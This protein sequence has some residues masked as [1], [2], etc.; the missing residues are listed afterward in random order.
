MHAAN[1]H[2][3]HP[4][5]QASWLA[6]QRA[7]KKKRWRD[8]EREYTNGASLDPDDIRFWMK[9]STLRFKLGERVEALEAAREAWKRAPEN[10]LTCELLSVT[11]TNQHRHS[12]AADVM[13][14]M[15]PGP[16]RTTEHLLNLAQALARAHRWSEV[17]SPCLEILGKDVFN[18]SAHLQ[19]GLAFHKMGRPR[20]AA[21]C[22]ETAAAADKTGRV[23]ALALSQLV[24]QLRYAAEWADL[25]RH[26]AALLT[27]LRDSDDTTLAQLVAFP[28]LSIDCPPDLQRRIARLSTN[29]MA[30]DIEPLP[31]R[32]PRAPG[33]LRIGYL[34][35]DFHSHATAL[36]IVEMLEHHDPS[37]VEVFLYCHSEQ[38]GSAMQQRL[39]ATAKCFRDVRH[40]G[41]AELA[42]LIRDDGIDIVIDLKGQTTDTRFHLLVSRPAPV[43]V[44]FLG[45][46]GTCGA[47]FLDYIVGDPIVTPLD[48]ADHYSERIA[49][50]PVCYQPNDSRRILPPAPTRAELGL[51]DDAVVLCCFNQT[52]KI[53]PAMADHWARIL[54]GAPKAVLWLL[55][56]NQQASANVVR[57]LQA[58]GVSPE[59]IFFSPLA[60]VPEHQARLQCADLFLDTWPYNAHTTA[61]EALWGG[62]PVLTVPGATFAARVAA[63]LVTACGL[64]EFACDTPDAYVDRAIALA[65]DPAPLREARRHLVEN[66]HQLPLF[67]GARFARDFE[68]L[69]QRMWDR[70]AA[71][72]APDHL[73]AITP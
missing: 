19:M 32:P 11:L 62:V 22:F 71:G 38:D 72:L 4:Q 13:L 8:A 10:P 30:A 41:D 1:P 49:Q 21:I 61:S 31:P 37:R 63:S 73:T 43:Q 16:G 26:T 60:T 28:L 55:V 7:E 66:R 64:P 34:S 69:L 54:K 51:P 9:V 39:R 12:E 45:Y 6:G 20:D 48:T 53:L 40:L 56:W 57:E 24:E 35:S 58:R 25:P 5:A 15:P 68:A 2:A 17:I 36:L 47:N 27:A 52:Y 44:S 46:P 42:K 23:K 59:R 50:M 3:R 29:R 67:D 70:H 18:A 65:N 33:P 14:A